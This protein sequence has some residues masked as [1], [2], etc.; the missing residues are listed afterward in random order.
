MDGVKFE[1]RHP[2]D[3][4]RVRVIPVIVIVI[5]IAM[6]RET[7]DATYLTTDGGKETVTEIIW[8][9]TGSAFVGY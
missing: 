2:T 8:W 7:I 5:G 3:E 9:F 4:K 1:L 6:Q